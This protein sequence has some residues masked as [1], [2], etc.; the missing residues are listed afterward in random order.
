MINIQS[1]EFSKTQQRHLRKI[2][3]AKQPKPR[4]ATPESQ[5]PKIQPSSPLLEPNEEQTMHDS[6]PNTQMFIMN[7]QEIHSSTQQTPFKRPESKNTIN[8][9]RNPPVPRTIGAFIGDI[10]IPKTFEEWNVRIRSD[11]ELLRQA[12]GMVRDN[13]DYVRQLVNEY[14]KKN[15]GKLDGASIP[16]TCS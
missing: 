11:K 10:E 15:P 8:E 1:P 14:K 12:A 5:P 3:E 7:L 9:P 6:M 13:P 4:V 16:H 2:M